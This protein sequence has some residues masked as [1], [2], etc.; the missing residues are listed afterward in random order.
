MVLFF[1]KSHTQ[2]TV[3]ALMAPSVNVVDKCMLWAAF[4]VAFYG[5]L[6]ANEFCAPFAHTCDPNYCTLLCADLSLATSQ[7][8]IIIK[9]PKTHPFQKSCT[10]MLCATHTCTCPVAALRNYLDHVTLQP[11]T[12]FFQF[13]NGTFLTGTAITTKLR[14]LLKLAI[15]K[16]D[17]FTSHSF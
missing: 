13:Q 7:A 10:V 3:L 12:T 17:T 15:C 16:P 2:L 1:F 11:G 14:V 8:R 5:F 4:C 6:R 9:V